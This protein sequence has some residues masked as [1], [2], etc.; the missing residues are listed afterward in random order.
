MPRST[1]SPAT[2]SAPSEVSR[3]G[4][5]PLGRLA[6]LE[7][8]HDQGQRREQ[9][10]AADEHDDAEHDR[11]AQQDDRHDEE[12][13]DGAGHPGRDVVGVAD[14]PEVAGEAGDDLA[15]R[16]PSGER[17]PGPPHRS[18]GDHGGA[19]RRDQPVAHGEPVPPVGRH[20]ADQAQAHDRAGPDEQGLLVV[21]DEAVDGLADRGRDEGDRQHPRHTEQH[22]PE[23][24]SPLAPSEPHEVAVGVQRRGLVRV[25]RVGPVVVRHQSST[26]GA[27]P[28]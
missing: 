21:R 3:P 13:H 1:R 24:G 11:A 26:L 2:V 25:D 15:G 17:R 28:A 16:H 9:H 12:A 10:R 4:L 20:G 27:A 22:A 5:V 18:L 23:D 14:P 8:P 19:E 6:P 7:R